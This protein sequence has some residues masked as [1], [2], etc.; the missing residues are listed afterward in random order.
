VWVGLEL[1]L[2]LDLGKHLGRRRGGENHV[3]IL[4]LDLPA[5]EDMVALCRGEDGFEDVMGPILLQYEL[6]KL[7]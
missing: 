2:E 7:Q 6:G 4:H 3:Q 1:D 5:D